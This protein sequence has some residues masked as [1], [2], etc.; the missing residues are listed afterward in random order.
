M[1]TRVQESDYDDWRKLIRVLSYLKYTL[2]LHVTIHCKQIDNLTWY[3]DGSYATHADMTGQSGAVLVTGGCVVLSRSN[4]EKVNTRSSTEVELIAVDDAVPTVQWEK[5]FMKEQGYD[6][7]TLI[8]EDNR[9]TMLLI[10]NGRLSSGKRMKHLDIRY[11]YVK[12]LVDRGVIHISHCISED[13]IPDFFT[14]PLQ[15]RQFQM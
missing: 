9:S 14:K 8:K 6:L 5:S 11:F 3:I 10:K 4:K 2:S 13:M 12:D 7:D 15:G 1:T